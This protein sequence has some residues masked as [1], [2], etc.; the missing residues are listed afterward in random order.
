MIHVLLDF[1]KASDKVSHSR[2]LYIIDYYGV[3]GIA[4]SWIKAFLSNRKQE[5]VLEVVLE[6]HHS[7]QAEVLSGVPQGTVLGPLLFL[8]YI[9]DL[10][11]SLKSS[12]TRLRGYKTFF[13]LN[14]TEHEISNCS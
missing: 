1:E 14:S 13:M 12:Y 5:V 6:G 3:R 4:H 9:D 11:D 8:A 2:L 7:I 10:P